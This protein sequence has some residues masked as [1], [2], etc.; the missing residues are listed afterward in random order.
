[1]LLRSTNFSLL[2]IWTVA[3]VDNVKSNAP[4]VDYIKIYFGDNKYA[5]F[6]LSSSQAVCELLNPRRLVK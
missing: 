6:T 1:M 2:M 4:N 3:D 5:F